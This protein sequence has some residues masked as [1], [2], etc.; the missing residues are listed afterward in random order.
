M[1]VL[2]SNR[3]LEIVRGDCSDVGGAPS[4]R[5][6]TR[7]Q[8]G[9]GWM[10]AATSG[11]LPDARTGAEWLPTNGGV[12]R[13]RSARRRT[14]VPSS[15]RIALYPDALLRAGPPS[16]RPGLPARRR[17]K[18][19]HCW[20][21]ERERR[22]LPESSALG[23]LRGAARAA[24]TESVAALAS[25]FPQRRRGDGV[26]SS[27]GTEGARDAVL[28]DRMAVARR[29]PAPAASGRRRVGNL[30]ES[31]RPRRPRSP[32]GGHTRL[33]SRTRRKFPLKIR[34][35]CRIN[36]PRDRLC[37]KTAACGRRL[38]GLGSQ[39]SRGQ[40]AALAFTAAASW[41]R[42]CSTRTHP[43]RLDWFT[44]VSP[45]RVAHIVA[46]DDGTAWRNPSA[47]QPGHSG[48]APPPGLAAPGGA[49]GRGGRRRNIVHRHR[50]SWRQ[51]R[52]HRD[53]GPPS[54][55]DLHRPCGAAPRALALASGPGRSAW[56]APRGDRPR[57]CRPD[58]DRRPVSPRD[59]L[60]RPDRERVPGGRLCPRAD[61]QGSCSTARAQTES[62][63][64]HRR[65]RVTEQ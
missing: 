1:S 53:G 10:Q 34:S 61:F 55:A 41:S 9:F 19:R 20:A 47:P 49:R 43:G 22:P 11:S 54:G 64:R 7:R 38:G 28:A 21:R 63:D 23:G 42:T 37:R 6:R 29:R 57:I 51:D 31:K 39:T 5:R 15:H 35:T 58:T 48:P 26:R 12:A 40:R 2:L 25:G 33:S 44:A 45:P 24:G 50:R 27:T 56:C 4:I 16:A 36:D 30:Q 65:P 14:E 17:E 8:C 62:R 13:S 3:A 60:S 59:R 52:G 18:A 32:V 46:S